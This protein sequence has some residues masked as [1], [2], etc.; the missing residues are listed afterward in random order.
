MIRILAL[1]FSFLLPITAA[2]QSVPVR[3]GDH[4]G[5]SRLLLGFDAEARWE[6]GRVPGGFEFRAGNKAVEY[7]LVSV[8]DLITRNRIVDVLDRGD[9]RLFL[10]VDCICHGDAFDLRDGQVVLDIKDGRPQNPAHPFEQGLEELTLQ[11]PSVSLPDLAQQ[12]QVAPPFARIFDGL[13]QPP[14]RIEL[15]LAFEQAWPTGN[16]MSLAL[17]PAP[18]ENDKPPAPSETSSAAPEQTGNAPETIPEPQESGSRAS[19]MQSLL[20]EQIARAAAQGLLEADL[21]PITVDPAAVPSPEVVPPDAAKA[22]PAPT[23]RKPPTDRSHMEVETGVDRAASESRASVI[24][25][26]GDHCIPSEFFDVSSWGGAGETFAQ[27]LGA[28]RGQTIGEFDK[29][30]SDGVTGLVRYYIYMTFG[31]EAL[32]MMRNN[33]NDVARSDLLEIMAEIMDTGVS[34]NAALLVDQMACKGETALWSVL[35][36]PRLDRSREINTNAVAL[37]FA[38]L[39]PHIRI[40]LGAPLL[41]KLLEAGDLEAADSVKNAMDLATPAGSGDLDAIALRFD[42]MRDDADT[43][44]GRLDEMLAKDDVSMPDAF[45]DHVD[46]E[47]GRGRLI[48]DE[49]ISLLESLA[50][51]RRGSDEST[52]FLVTAIRARALSGDFATAFSGLVDFRD[53]SSLNERERRDLV[54]EVFRRLNEDAADETFLRYLLPRLDLVVGL[55]ADERRGLAE[56][57]LDLGLT[58]PARI[59][60]EGQDSLPGPQDRFLFARAAMLD[61]RPDVAIGYLAGI[62]NEV[63]NGLRAEA[64]EAAGDFG[65]AFRAYLASGDTDSAGRMAWQGEL[66]DDLAKIGEGTVRDVAHLMRDPDAVDKRSTSE[67]PQ[68][69]LAGALG[70]IDESRT[71]RAILESLLDHNPSAGSGDM[72]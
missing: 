3:S 53:M 35:A 42:R 64:L 52:P 44:R 27:D 72:D 37:S 19:E 33:P 47:L 58:S 15:P 40:H 12:R 50:F 68:V 32:A 30:D 1:V 20:L 2:A 8:F 24:T 22:E 59:V 13:G 36:Q 23:G 46:A 26:A 29:S 63:A 67:E 39:P 16:A 57:L 25:G 11:A 55:P 56:R 61:G 6:F 10:K 14:D 21:E 51:E 17:P 69:S 62:E 54:G 7:N 18:L 65:G 4:A 66:W 31:A 71:S 45:L 28:F 38:G 9:G 60:L 48:P 43:A 49:Q 70:V 5:F 41:N 34:R